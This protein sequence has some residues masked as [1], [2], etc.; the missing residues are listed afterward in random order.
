MKSLK[1]Y[2]NAKVN[3]GLHIEGRREDGTRRSGDADP[4]SGGDAGES[5]IDGRAERGGLQQ[6]GAGG[7]DEFRR[8]DQADL[9]GAGGR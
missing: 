5:G 7:F 3:L 4:G 6:D 9:R 8:G 2:P 1:V